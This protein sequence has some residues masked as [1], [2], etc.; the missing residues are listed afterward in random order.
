MFNDIDKTRLQ[1]ERELWIV[2]RKPGK[3]MFLFSNTLW[4]SVS[5]VTLFRTP[6]IGHF[7]Y[8]RTM[9]YHQR[10]ATFWVVLPLSLG[11]GILIALAMWRRGERLVNSA[12]GVDV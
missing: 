7:W 10:M 2:R 3:K 5:C 6:F 8:G 4:I 1:R 12:D 11:L 9:T